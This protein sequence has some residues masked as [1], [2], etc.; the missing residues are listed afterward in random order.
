[1][2]PKKADAVLT[3]GK[4]VNALPNRRSGGPVP[5]VNPFKGVVNCADLP[6]IVRGTGGTEPIRVRAVCNDWAPQG[7]RGVGMSGDEDPLILLR[8][9]PRRRSHPWC[10]GRCQGWREGFHPESAAELCT[11]QLSYVI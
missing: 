8:P 10:T 11:P 4:E 1:M 3:V 6:S 5:V 2:S 7:G 9:D